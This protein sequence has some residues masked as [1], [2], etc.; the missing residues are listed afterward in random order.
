MDKSRGGQFTSA[1]WEIHLKG[2]SVFPQAKLYQAEF[3]PLYR[4]ERIVSEHRVYQS[5]Q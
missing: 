2:L 5:Y 3:H 4:T 1:G